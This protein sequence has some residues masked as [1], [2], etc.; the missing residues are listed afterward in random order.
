[1]DSHGPVLRVFEARAK[2]GCAGKLLENFATTS[3]E[4]VRS[5]P[6]NG[7]YFF[8]RCVQGDENTVLFVSA[9]KDLAAVKARFGDAWQEA[10]MPEGYEELI[11]ACSVRHFDMRRGWHVRNR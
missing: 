10:H 3:A 4:V 7:G 2:P 1:M 6:G 5:E 9:W 11:D 8:G